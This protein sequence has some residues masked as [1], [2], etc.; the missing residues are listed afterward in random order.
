[1]SFGASNDRFIKY[2]RSRQVKALAAGTEEHVVADGI[3]L[4]SSLCSIR[5]VALC[6]ENDLMWGQHGQ[7]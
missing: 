3:C 4:H 6:M 7:Q 5:C 1:M 2:D